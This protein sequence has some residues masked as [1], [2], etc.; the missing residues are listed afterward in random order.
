M[1]VRTHILEAIQYPTVDFHM[2]QSLS[3]MILSGVFESYPTLRVGAVEFEVSWAPYFMGRLDDAYQ[4]RAAGQA[5][6]RFRG[7]DLPSDFFRRNV[8]ISFQEDDLGIQLR[9]HVGVDNLLWGSDYPH[10]ESTFPRSRQ[11]VERILKDVPQQEKA[12]IVGE[13]AARLYHFH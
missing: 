13:N 9:H 10:A 2:R 5:G 12:K 1:D 7:A 3:A 11:I 4:Q 8:F 6:F